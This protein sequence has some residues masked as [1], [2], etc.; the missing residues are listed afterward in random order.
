MPLDGTLILPG[1]LAIRNRDPN[2]WCDDPLLLLGLPE[3][4]FWLCRT[5]RNPPWLLEAGTGNSLPKQAGYL[6][7]SVYEAVRGLGVLRQ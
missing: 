3:V 2:G 1:L 7:I 6:G 4:S 5:N